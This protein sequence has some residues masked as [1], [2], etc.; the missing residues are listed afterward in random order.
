V[1]L[2]AALA[3]V[4]LV[5]APGLARAYVG[6][7]ELTNA[8]DAEVALHP[9]DAELRLQRARVLLL[10]RQWRAALAELDAAA[11]RGADPAVV[12]TTRGRVLLEAGKARAARVELDRVLRRHPAAYDALFERGRACL[13]LGDAQQAAADFGHALERLETP[14]PEHVMAR[15]DALV[16]LGRRADA[17]QAL[18]EGMARIGHVASLELAAIDL[19]SEMGLHASALRRIDRLLAAMP[20]NPAWVAVRAELLQRTGRADEAR[21]DY[22]RALGMIDARPREERGSAFEDLRR[23][24]QTA[25]AAG[26]GN[27]AP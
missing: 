20:Q 12:G 11:S 27:A 13:A 21:A 23:Q 4:G 6:L 9:D 25:L 8:L 17:V 2:L 1:R 18:D 26:R 5:A 15:R 7:D 10:T 19:E 3:L 22:A 16:A 14:R 24:L